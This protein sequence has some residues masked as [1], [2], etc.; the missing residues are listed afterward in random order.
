[1]S[2]TFDIGDVV[3]LKSGSPEM[4]IIRLDFPLDPVKEAAQLVFYVTDK[5][6]PLVFTYLPTQ[7]LEHRV[8]D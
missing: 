7:A 3:V 8:Q 2:K 4:T 5:D 6:D 1:M